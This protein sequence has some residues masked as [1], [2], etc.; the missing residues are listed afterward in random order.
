VAPA[1]G[2]ALWLAVWVHVEADGLILA[3]VASGPLSGMLV[4]DVLNAVRDVEPEYPTGNLAQY[5]RELTSEA[6]GNILTFGLGC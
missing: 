3:A 6:R 5:L 2:L 4:S 1:P